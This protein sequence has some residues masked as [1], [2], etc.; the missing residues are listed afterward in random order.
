[1]CNGEEEAKRLHRKMGGDGVGGGFL[2]IRLLEVGRD[3]FQSK[4]Q[5]KTPLE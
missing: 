5:R 4:A 2:S 1:M 3:K